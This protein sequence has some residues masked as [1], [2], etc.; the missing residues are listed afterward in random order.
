MNIHAVNVP[1]KNLELY[2]RIL[3]GMEPNTFFI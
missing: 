1:S 3:C 2:G